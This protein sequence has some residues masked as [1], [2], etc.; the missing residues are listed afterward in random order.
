MFP[1]SEI[2]K[3]SSKQMTKFAQTINFAQAS[4]SP[5]D[6][7]N[8]KVAIDESFNDYLKKFN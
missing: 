1:D 6:L 2:Y 8:K 5:S 7:E 4:F 3:G